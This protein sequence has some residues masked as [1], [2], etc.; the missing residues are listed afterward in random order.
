MLKK[1]EFCRKSGWIWSKL[2]KHL[3][4][5]EQYRENIILL[6]FFVSDTVLEL[7]HDKMLV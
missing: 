3:K 6:Q 2:L 1:K 4:F 5:I 7:D